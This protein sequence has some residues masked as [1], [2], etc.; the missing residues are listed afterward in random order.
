MLSTP[1]KAIKTKASESKMC[2][3][4]E[5]PIVL[6]QSLLP[7]V[8]SLIFVISQALESSPKRKPAKE[9]NTMRGTYEKTELYAKAVS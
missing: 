1:P 5:L 9:P 2:A 4:D 3:I 8:I 6:T 7:F